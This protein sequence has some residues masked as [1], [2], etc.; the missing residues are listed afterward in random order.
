M[1]PGYGLK[2][3]SLIVLAFQ[4][5]APLSEGHM[6]SL[7]QVLTKQWQIDW[8]L[9]RV[10]ERTH[11]PVFVSSACSCTQT[12]VAEHEPPHLA[13]HPQEPLIML[14]AVPTQAGGMEL[15]Q[16]AVMGEPFLT[17]PL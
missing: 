5:K 11:C 14:F 12:K 13:S 8:E 7:M 2:W 10:W 4:F 1:L 6:P 17:V 9:R 15:W 16:P 3:L